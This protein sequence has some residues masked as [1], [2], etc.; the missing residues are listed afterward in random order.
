[1]T[2]SR[3]S[4]VDRLDGECAYARRAEREPLEGADDPQRRAGRLGQRDSGVKRSPRLFQS[5][6]TDADP[7]ERARVAVAVAPR[8]NCD[9]T[10][11]ARDETLADAAEQQ[12]ADGS[13]CRRSDD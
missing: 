9:R 1:V 5:V 13:A 4:G 12:S 7:V 8:R 2:S 3:R 11:G 10:G 6:E